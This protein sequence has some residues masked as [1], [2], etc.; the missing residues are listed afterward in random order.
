LRLATRRSTQGLRAVHML[1]FRLPWLPE[2]LVLAGDA[3]GL[4]AFLVRSGL[5]R[6][7][8]DHYVRRMQQ[9]GALSAALGWYRSI[10]ASRGQGPRRVDV[11]TTHL[12]GRHDPF[13]TPTAARL[14][15]EFVRGPFRSVDL[16]AGHWLP[17]TR[18]DEV[19]AAVLHRVRSLSGGGAGELG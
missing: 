12:W 5:P 7:Q 11:P 10:R 4:R 14:T 18:P 16:D 17:E 9:P 3:R 2:R 19:A 13:F 1:L 15:R 8:A 6:G